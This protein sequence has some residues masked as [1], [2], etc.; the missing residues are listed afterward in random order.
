MNFRALNISDINCPR[1]PRI[2][3][4]ESQIYDS[5]ELER[6][7]DSLKNH[8]KFYI[9]ESQILKNTPLSIDDMEIDDD[10]TYNESFNFDKW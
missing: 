10:L 2:F 4:K 1:L 7:F 8:S 3:F 9:D 6:L 5:V